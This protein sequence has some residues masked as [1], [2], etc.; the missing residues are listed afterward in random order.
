MHLCFVNAADC[1]LARSF[2]Q[3]APAATTSDPDLP[4][5]VAVVEAYGSV[6][7]SEP[8]DRVEARHVLEAEAAS[9]W[10]SVVV[11]VLDPS[12]PTEGPTRFASAHFSA[13]H[14]HA[15]FVFPYGELRDSVAYYR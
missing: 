3:A 11:L 2:Q 5:V 12:T 14:D 10:P 9:N 15:P 4:T 7:T 6:R 1:P 13:S 8:L